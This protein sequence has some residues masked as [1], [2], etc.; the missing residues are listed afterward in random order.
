MK[1]LVVQQRADAQRVTGCARVVSVIIINSVLLVWLADDTLEKHRGETK[2][3]LSSIRKP[4]EIICVSVRCLIHL[5]YSAIRVSVIHIYISSVC[6]CISRQRWYFFLWP[7]K[8]T[9]TRK[10]PMYRQLTDPYTM[11]YVFFFAYIRAFMRLYGFT[12]ALSTYMIWRG[13]INKL[14]GRYKEPEG[15]TANG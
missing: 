15:L 4:S 7:L 12:A 9:V 10:L 2:T 13:G 11:I 1:R 14:I 8:M 3:R 5:H 6:L